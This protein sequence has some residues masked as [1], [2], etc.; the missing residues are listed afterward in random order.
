MKTL[1]NKPDLD[2]FVSEHKG[3]KVVLDVYADWCGP[4]KIM[5]PVF[6]NVIAELGSK[7]IAAK[8]DSDALQDELAAHNISITTI[9]RFLV[10]EIST[11]GSLSLIEDMGG[12]QTKTSL[13]E[14]ITNQVV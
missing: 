3:K 2:A 5:T 6:E 14:K 11:N 12:T 1:L 10:V 7:V 9:P 13:V 8:L 4:C